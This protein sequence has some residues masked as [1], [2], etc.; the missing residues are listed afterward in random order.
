MTDT[1]AGRVL[2]AAIKSLRTEILPQ[3]KDDAIRIRFDQITRLLIGVSA[4]ISR[5][6]QGLRELLQKAG[7]TG[8]LDVEEPAEDATIEELEQRRIE[9][10]RS[11]S[12]QLPA[13]LDAAAD[14]ADGVAA[15]ERFV[16][17]QKAFYLSQDADIAHGSAVVYRGGRIESPPAPPASRWPELNEASLT[18]YL[19]KRLGHDDV[20]AVKVRAIAGGFS[21][22][23]V[24]FTLHDAAAGTEQPLV[25]RKDMPVPFINKTVFNEFQLLQ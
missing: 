8:L 13:L 3:L 9:L 18:A 12:Q 5:R 10:E 11:I 1:S 24:F 21:K 23:T 25:I 2:D 4:R 17:W 22:Q 16:E 19:R 14:G 7:G 20:S 15:L 6:E